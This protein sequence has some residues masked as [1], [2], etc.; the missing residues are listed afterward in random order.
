[1]ELKENYVHV[2]LGPMEHKGVMF[3]SYKEFCSS[4]MT[5]L[6]KQVC[7]SKLHMSLLCVID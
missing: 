1:M 5:L 4:D 7:Y 3:S 2:I 6:Q